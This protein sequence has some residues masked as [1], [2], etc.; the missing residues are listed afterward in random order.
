MLT[1]L[2]SM[3]CL[4]TVM[5][6]IPSAVKS[7][8]SVACYGHLVT[9]TYIHYIHIYKFIYIAKN[10]EN[11]SEALSDKRNSATSSQV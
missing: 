3:W 4:C 6:T 5:D 1:I 11:E 9:A 2:K 10:R 7:I 8:H